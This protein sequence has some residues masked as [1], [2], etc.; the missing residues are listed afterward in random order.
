[1]DKEIMKTLRIATRKSR[2]ALWQAE[3]VAGLLRQRFPAL[4]IELVPLTTRGD[5][6]LDRSLLEIG[7]KGLF[8]K[9]LERALLDGAADIAVHSLKDVPAEMT[10][11]LDVPVFLP[12]EVVD[13]AWIAAAGH[14]PRALPAGSRV[15]TSSLRRQA[16][17]LRLRPDLDVVPLRGNVET[18]LGRLEEATCEAVILAR[19]GLKRLGLEARMTHAL[20]PPDW[21]PAPGQ[22]VIC[23]QCRDCAPAVRALIDTL[24]CSDTQTTAMA[25]RAV[26]AAL[27]GDCRMP[28]AALAQ[29]H[30]DVLELRVCLFNADGTECIEASRS[31]ASSTAAALG[32]RAA[33]DIRRQ[34][35]QALIEA[36]N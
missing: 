26:V 34:G 22:G 25:E 23:I 9:E 3:H 27:G 12:R 19:A 7:G 4:A 33:D 35:G 31:G 28:L 29:I 11:G 5:I 15:G 1:M 10:P 20:A 8:L 17:L 6:E 14:G 32:Q 30:G 24:N 18:R 2:L 36:L 13:D 21:L 16:Q